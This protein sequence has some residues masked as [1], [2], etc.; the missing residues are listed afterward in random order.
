MASFRVKSG[1]FWGKKWHLLGCMLPTYNFLLPF[2]FIN[3]AFCFIMVPLETVSRKT[4]DGQKEIFYLI[5]TRQPR[6]DFEKMCNMI[7]ERTTISPHEVSFVLAELQ[8]VVVENLQLGRGIELGRLGSLEPSLNAKSVKNI[9]EINLKTVKK[10]RLIYKPSKQI[11]KALKNL[12]F[13]ISK[14]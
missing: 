14:P 4:A 5:I 2:Y 8:E 12:R 10:V 3:I 9:D 1:I 13:K 11:K 6:L 7:A